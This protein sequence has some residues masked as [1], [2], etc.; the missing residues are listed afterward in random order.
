[1]LPYDLKN[2][3]NAAVA[4]KSQ[5]ITASG[6]SAAINMLGNTLA[7]LFAF[8]VSAATAGTLPTF[9]AKIQQSADGST[10]WTDVTGASITQ[11]TTVDSIQTV[12]VDPRGTQQYLRVNY[13]IGGSASPAFPVGVVILTGKQYKP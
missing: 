7:V 12:G 5:S 2:E 6:N 10:N 11:V 8:N 4:L 9:D 13:T 1:M 3:I